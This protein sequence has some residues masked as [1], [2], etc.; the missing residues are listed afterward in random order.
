M[1]NI[2]PPPIYQGLFDTTQQPINGKATLPWILFFNQVFTG[3]LGT[4]WTPTFLNLTTVGTPTITGTYYRIGQGLVYF[5]VR[6]LP[7]TST[8]SVAGTTQITNFP[9]KFNAD[10]ACLAVAG[11]GGGGNPGQMLANT[12]IIDVPSWTAV[13]VPLTIVGFGEAS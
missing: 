9:L 13:T 1:S 8:T 4:A 10:G 6:I 3:D 5:S 2:Q 7:A 12:T 11:G